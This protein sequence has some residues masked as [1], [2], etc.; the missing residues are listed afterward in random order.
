M[1]YLYTAALLLVFSLSFTLGNSKECDGAYP[2]LPPGE[3]SRCRAC[4]DGCQH[5]PQYCCTGTGCWCKEACS[6]SDPNANCDYLGDDWKKLR[7]TNCAPWYPYECWVDF[8]CCPSHCDNFYGSKCT[9]CGSSACP[10]IPSARALLERGLLRGNGW[11]K[12]Q[13]ESDLD[14]WWDL[15]A[16][17]L[18]CW[19]FIF[20]KCKTWIPIALSPVESRWIIRS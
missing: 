15:V 18:F 10:R 9:G 6:G 5:V 3:T 8:Y 7:K 13:D 20:M 17:E 1:K 4:L 12:G 11:R 16:F 2:K 19:L 14:L